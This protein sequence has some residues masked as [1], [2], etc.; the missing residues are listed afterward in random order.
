MKPR[1]NQ[2]L[3]HRSESAEYLVFFAILLVLLAA[4]A[5]RLEPMFKDALATLSGLLH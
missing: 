1:E 4:G 5:S 3:W 2:K